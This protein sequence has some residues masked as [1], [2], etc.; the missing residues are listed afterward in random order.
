MLDRGIGRR[1]AA[2]RGRPLVREV[3][4]A[5]E[6]QISKTRMRAMLLLLLL[7]LLLLAM[8]GH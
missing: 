5:Q 8:A 2:E 7:L 1:R 3:R 6:G 4:R